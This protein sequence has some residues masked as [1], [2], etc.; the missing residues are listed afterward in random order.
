M[1]SLS[2]GD[3]SVVINHTSI[4]EVTEERDVNFDLKKFWTTEE[5]PIKKLWSKE[6][7]ECEELYQKTTEKVTDDNKFTVHCP[8]KEYPL[9]IGESR[10]QAYHRLLALERKLALNPE[11]QST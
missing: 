4:G 9:D 8:F 11:K 5:V 6:E 1:G 2:S 10:G 3:E 7:K